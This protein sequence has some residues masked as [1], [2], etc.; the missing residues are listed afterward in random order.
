[1]EVKE[2]LQRF[3]VEMT[4]LEE[5]FLWADSAIIAYINK[6]QQDFCR[7]TEGIEDGVS[8]ITQIKVP[9]GSESVKLDPRI[10]KVRAATITDPNDPS[11]YPFRRELSLRAPERM[12]PFAFASGEPNYLIPGYGPHTWKIHGRSRRELLLQLVVFRLPAPI[13]GVDDSLEIDE[14]HHE[15]LMLGMAASAYGRPDPETIDLV[16][17]REFDGRFREYCEQARREQGRL[18]KPNGTTRFSW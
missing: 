17:T 1:M 15:H 8:S 9:A 16:K 14:H 12:A 18:R 13:T 11:M 4:D 6:A 5:P 7:L 3:R 10:L 2:L